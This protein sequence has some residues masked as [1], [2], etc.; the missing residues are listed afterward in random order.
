MGDGWQPKHTHSHHH[1]PLLHPD[2][3]G[4]A[5]KGVTVHRG[6]RVHHDFAQQRAQELLHEL[7]LLR[8]QS[9]HRDHKVM[10]H[11]SCATSHAPQ[12]T[13][14]PQV[15]HHKLQQEQGP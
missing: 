13:H 15:M 12:V 4:T 10:R 1:S 9:A 14:V 8:L 2:L 6:H 11:K 7:L 5:L 3:D